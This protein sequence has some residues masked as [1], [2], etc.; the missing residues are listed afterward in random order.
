M[1]GFL[2]PIV[3]SRIQGERGKYRVVKELSVG[4]MGY[5]YY[6]ESDNNEKVVIKAPLKKGDGFDDQRFEKLRVESQI[7]KSI[8]HA[9]IVKYVDQAF[10][11]NTFY[12]VIS[13]VDGKN[14]RD[15][16]W[17]Q[18]AQE[19]DAENHVLKLLDAVRY[20]HGINVIHRDINPRNVMLKSDL[21]LV[22]LDFGAA[23]QGFTQ[24]SA[25]GTQIGTPGWSAPEQ[26]TTGIV[27]ASSDIY[28]IGGV[29]F[30]LLTGQEPRLHM[31]SLGSLNS[32]PADVNPSVGQR[33]S[34]IVRLAMD[35]DPLNRFQTAKDMIDTIKGQSTALGVPHLIIS[36]TKHVLEKSI[37]LGRSHEC[38]PSCVER[39]FVE[40]LDVGIDDWD[41][42]ISKH[43]AKIYL[44]S[45]G[46]HWIEDLG[47][48]N[49]TAVAHRGRPF[50]IVPSRGKE[51]LKDKDTIA[52]VYSEN[53][54]PYL[55]LLFCM[56]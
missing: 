8:N 26:F 19:I 5:A 28:S 50:K 12:L 15:M 24:L 3:G 53:K 21:S 18:P 51:I 52:L 17:A 20:L 31:N 27:T 9:N 25:K 55:T 7:L 43:H 48:L 13:Y 46:T 40:P 4:G 37:E 14:M 39:G 34:D 47:S 32:S 49:Y 33:L 44:D 45:K 29:G 16:F 38:G 35:A 23:K 41:K 11:K 36:G 1:R 54:G 2:A 22:L 30:F 10:H 42:Y 6:G 56:S